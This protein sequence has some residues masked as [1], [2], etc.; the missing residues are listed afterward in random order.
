MV[1]PLRE[2]GQVAYL[3]RELEEQVVGAVAR[4]GRGVGRRLEVAKE[5]R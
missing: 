4:G 3:G 2:E 1:G 5:G